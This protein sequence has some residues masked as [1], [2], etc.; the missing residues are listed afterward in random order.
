MNTYIRTAFI[1]PVQ[2][3]EVYLN[4]T[5]FNHFLL[6]GKVD[7]RPEKICRKRP[8]RLLHRNSTGGGE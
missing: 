2:T 4:Y 7:F 5:K 6:Y 3:V 8:L 1:G